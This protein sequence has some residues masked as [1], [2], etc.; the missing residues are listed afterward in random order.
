MDTASLHSSG[1][2]PKQLDLLLCLLLVSEDPAAPGTVKPAG[3]S[4]EGVSS[5]EDDALGY[6][7]C[8][9]GY[10]VVLKN[11]RLGIPGRTG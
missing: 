3:I 4:P 11:S 10:R 5:C 6:H 7:G 2:P 1:H 8:C 9:A